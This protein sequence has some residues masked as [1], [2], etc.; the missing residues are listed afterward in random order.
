[1]VDPP[2]TAWAW[3]SLTSAKR[4]VLL[5][6]LVHGPRSRSQLTRRTG[7]SRATLS[8]LTRDLT[9]AGLL[10][11]GVPAEV[12]GPGRPSDVVALRADGGR[13]VGLKLTGTTLYVVVTDLGAGVLHT[14][15]I[16]LA[17]RDVDDVVATMAGAVL[18]ARSAF[19]RV[20]AVGVCLAGD[21]HVVDGSAWVI[22]SDFLGWD[23]VPLEAAVVAATGL[24][25]AISNDV[26]ALTVAHHW[27]GAGRGAASLAVV[28]VGA[29]VGAGLV[30][31][32]TLLRGAHGRPGKVSHLI[33]TGGG[34]RCDRGHVGCASAYVT[35]PAV[36][37]N[38]GL[39]SFDDV[40]RA[41]EAGERR[42]DRALR[43]AGTALGALAAN[44]V[45]LIDPEKVVLTGEGRAVGEYARAELDAALRRRLDPSAIAPPVEVHPFAFT[46]YAWGAAITAIR[47]LV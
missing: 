47:H 30:L 43:E 12:L 10:R 31:D 2:G 36:L 28:A 35:V 42:A 46:D 39:S 7:L 5:D 45:N 17:S 24:P 13:F 18:R 44:L 32:G 11:D 37:A 40:L 33:V 3:P 26:Q 20:S 19:P 15:E 8:R 6:V 1:M 23:R 29:G 25:T 27:F 38:A 9:E 22:G 34:P 16:G 21:V 4:T 14:E 41:A